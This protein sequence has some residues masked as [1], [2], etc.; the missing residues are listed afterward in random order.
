[1][2]LMIA[3]DNDKKIEAS[4]I[5][6]EFDALR[7]RIDSSVINSPISLDAALTL[8]LN[9]LVRL[10][11]ATIPQRRAIYQAIQTGQES[12]LTRIGADETTVDF[13][14]RQLRM[15]MRY[16]EQDIRAG[17]DVLAEG[18][19]STALIRDH[20]R[21][22]AGYSTRVAQ[23]KNQAAREARRLAGQSSQ[24]MSES[25]TPS[26]AEQCNSL[27]TRLNRIHS[28]QLLRPLPRGRAWPTTL[29][30]LV[31]YLIHVIRNESRVA[32]LWA[33]LGPAV[34]LAL[35]SAPY[36]LTG[37]RYILGMDVATFSLLGA[38]TWVMFR[39]IIFRSSSN[40]I[41]SRALID[42]NAIT[43]L[44]HAL[45]YALIYLGIFLTVYLVLISVGVYINQ[46]TPPDQWKKFL[47]YVLMMALG[48]TSLGILFG[49]IAAFWPYFLR[50]AAVIER[51]LQVFS[52]V[53]LVSEQLPEQYR[54]Y[55]LWSPFAHGM[56]LLRSAY[57]HNYKSE[58]ASV[59]YFFIAL[60]LL[61][62]ISLFT[63]RLA[64]SNI[65]PM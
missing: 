21:L 28:T 30:P 25:L 5:D 34:L 2:S 59:S 19:Q 36:F 37:V 27:S 9:A 58:D 56:Q 41:A 35:I 45:A 26:E 24:L 53:F 42:L 11:H 65:Q 49:S 12:G 38:I 18:Y 52:G 48:A 44:Q 7:Q 47:F 20:Q 3:Q 14:Y 23:Q 32:L 50:F 51:I 64:R 10:P 63:E 54:K 15:I 22:E 60:I 8:F 1:M 40:Y 4:S 17:I 62:A 33:F 16:L 61:L 46:V 43:P 57:F 29:G 13:C 39:Q 31:A 55:F 6:M